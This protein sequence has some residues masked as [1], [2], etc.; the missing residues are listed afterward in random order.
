MLAPAQVE[1]VFVN[2]KKGEF[3]AKSDLQ[4][5]FPGKEEMEIIQE[6]LGKVW[7]RFKLL[8]SDFFSAMCLFSGVHSHS[9][10]NEFLSFLPLLV[11]HS[12][13]IDNF[14]FFILHFP[15]R[16]ICTLPQADD[17]LKEWCGEGWP[18]ALQSLESLL[19]KS[20]Y[21]TVGFC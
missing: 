6:I 12:S 13:F 3:A 11:V 8:A 7:F 18:S 15:L 17:L 9:E 4:R 20:S 14:Q 10:L 16:L 5:I 1:R 21:A 2:V 19:T